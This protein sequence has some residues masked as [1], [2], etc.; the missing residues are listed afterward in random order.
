[1]A[2]HGCIV[3]CA[4]TKGMMTHPNFMFVLL[5]PLASTRNPSLHTPYIISV[6]F[7]KNLC[8]RICVCVCVCVCVHTHAR[9]HARTRTCRQTAN[10]YSEKPPLM[11]C[12]SANTFTTT[13]LCSVRTFLIRTLLSCVFFTQVEC[14]STLLSR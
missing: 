3:L 5:L 13:T 2:S 10:A 1:M 11:S 4:S 8:I 12:H 6:Y 9:P 14:N 7:Y